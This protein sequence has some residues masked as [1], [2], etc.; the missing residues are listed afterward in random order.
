MTGKLFYS[1]NFIKNLLIVEAL[2]KTDRETP[3][4]SR[5]IL[6]E[7]ERRWKKLFRNKPLD[8]SSKKKMIPATISRHVFD[9]NQ[10]GLYKICL[11][12]D[13][14]KG[15]YN[16]NRLLTTAEVGVI[17]A[18]IYGMSLSVDEKKILLEKIKS[19]TDTDGSSIVSGFERQMKLEPKGIQPSLQKIQIINKAIVESKKITFYN[20][21]DRLIDDWEKVTASPQ[22]LFLKDDELYLTAKVENV[23]QDFKIKL[24]KHIEIQDEK[25][26]SEK[27]FSLR[28]HLSGVNENAPI[29][30]LKISFPQSFIEK[31]F[32]HFKRK[33]IVSFAPNGNFSEGER[34]F[35]ATIFLNE[36]EKLYEFLRSHCD[37]I[38]IFSPKCIKEKLNA[39]LSKALKLI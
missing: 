36:D 6:Q 14:K 2:Q 9:M 30:E 1:K 25:F 37:K 12:E 7:V 28:R 4:T 27:N 3:K 31:I 39:Q 5:Q 24:I 18:A 13:N 29:I 10:S 38:K 11:H 26:Q 20:R 8:E 15:Y 21:Q 19:V 16:A 22:I 23:R 17:S 33:R 35:R 32:E 34:Q